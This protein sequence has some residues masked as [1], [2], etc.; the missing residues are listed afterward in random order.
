MVFSPALRSMV[1][2]QEGGHGQ[3]GCREGSDNDDGLN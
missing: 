3:G 2:T 1:A